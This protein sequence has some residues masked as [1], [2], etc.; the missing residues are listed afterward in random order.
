MAA[1]DLVAAER[2][3]PDCLAMHDSRTLR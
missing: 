3:S 1:R 2:N